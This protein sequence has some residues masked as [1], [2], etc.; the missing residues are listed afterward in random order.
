MSLLG[1]SKTGLD[2]IFI[3]PSPKFSLSTNISF[4]DVYCNAGL[5]VFNFTLSLD[6]VQ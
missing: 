1:K 5:I 2:K 3:S 6:G 4:Y